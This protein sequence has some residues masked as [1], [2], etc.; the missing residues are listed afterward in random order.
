MITD[1]TIKVVTASLC[2]SLISLGCSR[3]QPFSLLDKKNRESEWEG[4]TFYCQTAVPKTLELQRLSRLSKWICVVCL[5]FLLSTK[6]PDQCSPWLA[7]KL[8][9]GGRWTGR[10]RPTLSFDLLR[11]EFTSPC[12]ENRNYNVAVN[13]S[14]SAELCPA[15]HRFINQIRLRM[16]KHLQFINHRA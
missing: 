13:S 6:L 10:G 15:E 2:G 8:C 7:P 11:H 16:H 12:S 9:K 3:R 4:E 5:F 14:C 1:I